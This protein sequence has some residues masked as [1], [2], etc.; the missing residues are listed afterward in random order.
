[1]LVLWLNQGHL[2][3]NQSRKQRAYANNERKCEQKLAIKLRR[4]NIDSTNQTIVLVS[5]GLVCEY[6]VVGGGFFFASLQGDKIGWL[7]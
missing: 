5:R 7:L 3:L 4:S 1:M 6:F 2:W